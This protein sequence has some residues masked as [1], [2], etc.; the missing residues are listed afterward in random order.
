M[1]IKDITEDN[2]KEV[3]NANLT[4]LHWK[5]HQ[6]W[7]QRKYK[8]MDTTSLKS[9]HT[10]VKAEMISRGLKHSEHAMKKVMSKISTYMEDLD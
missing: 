8:K 7:C 2:I 5:I 9:S 10:L 1:K 6:L 3:S 4:G